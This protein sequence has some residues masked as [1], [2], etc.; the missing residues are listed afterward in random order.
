MRY[1]GKKKDSVFG[2]GFQEGHTGYKVS[3]EWET[4]DIGKRAFHFLSWEVIGKAEFT[5]AAAT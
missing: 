3:P 4:G 1:V 2:R 5:P